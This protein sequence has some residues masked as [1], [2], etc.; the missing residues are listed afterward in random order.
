MSIESS[1]GTRER[2]NG[3]S[4]SPRRIRFTVEIVVEMDDGQS[5]NNE[6]S[7][8]LFLLDILREIRESYTLISDT[9]VVERRS[10]G[11]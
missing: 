9:Q 10:E 5:F 11:R 2:T 4:H 3:A 1:D 8:E 7:A 6:D